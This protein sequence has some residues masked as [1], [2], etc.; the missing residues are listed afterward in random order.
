MAA[1]T[2]G[3]NA[4][5]S[6]KFCRQPRLL[7]YSARALS[8][9]STTRISIITSHWNKSYH[10]LLPRHRSLTN[11]AAAGPP[12]PAGGAGRAQELHAPSA[13]HEAAHHQGCAALYTRA[14]ARPPA[15]P[16]HRVATTCCGV[17]RNTF[18]P[19]YCP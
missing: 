18:Y 19:L 15:R 17:K 8:R 3:T 14:E 10:P 4:V 6:H 11:C 7:Q 5:C 9:S 1:I 13:P 16:P 12:P 2:T